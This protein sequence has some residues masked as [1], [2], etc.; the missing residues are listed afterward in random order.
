ML[1]IL[2]G[3]TP[4]DL[5][6]GEEFTEYRKDPRTNKEVQLEAIEFAAYCPSRV[7]AAAVPTGVG[8][9]LIAVSVAK[10]TDLRTV[11]LTATKGLQ[12]Q[13]SDTFHKYGI[14]DIRGKSNYDCGDYAHLDCRQGASVGCRYCQGKGCAYEVARDRARNAQLVVAN[15]A[16]WLNVNDRASGIERTGEN[17]KYDGRNP[18]QL[19]VLDEAHTADQWLADYL[20]IRMYEGEVKRWTEPKDL[21]DSLGEWQGLAEVAVCDLKP[22]VEEAQL[23]LMKRGQRV[24]REEIDQ[25]HK[26][27]KLLEKFDRISSMGEDWVIDKWEGTRWGRMWAMDVTWPG[28]YAEQYLFCNIPKII[29]MSAT[30]RPKTVSLLGVK[31]EDAEFREWA[32]IFPANRHPIYSMPARTEA[33][34]DIRIDRRTSLSDKLEWVEHIDAI[35]DDRLDRKGII[36]TVCVEPKTLLLTT[37]LEWIRADHVVRGQGL[38]GFDESTEHMRGGHRR[39]RS[40]TAEYVKVI[41]RPCVRLYLEDSKNIVCSKDHLWLTHNGTW[42]SWT[43]ADRLMTGAGAS[44]H[45]MKV[46]DVWDYDPDW[47]TGYLAAAF[48]GE[49]CLHQRRR[50]LGGKFC[51]LNLQF[52]QKENCML[53]RVSGLLL[54]IGFEHTIYG[55]YDS[56]STANLRISNKSEVLRFLG[57]VRP[58]RLMDKLDLT[59]LGKMSLKKRVRVIK[60]EFIG[61]QKVISIKTGTSTFIAEGYA[62]HNSYER[63][64]FLIDHSRHSDIMIGNTSDPESETA[65]EIAGLFRK[66]LPPQILVSPSFA[67][68]WDFPDSECEYIIICKVPFKPGHSKVMKAREEKDKAYGSYLAMQEMVQGAGRGMRSNEDRCEVFITDGHLSWFLYQNKRLA[69]GWFVEAVRRVNKVPSA[70]GKL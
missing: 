59:G 55:N 58:Q 9:S 3:Y 6:F 51:G 50:S 27:E 68:G 2:S 16:Y 56:R 25:L 13:Y 34:K 23:V 36:Q 67:M 37:S 35:I 54:D 5:G 43:R 65:I 20:A 18:V 15:Y 21:G 42:P 57:Q 32:R 30:L 39:W 61:V 38:M 4:R 47:T 1:D 62:S 64:K 46:I 70:P 53:K 44:S 63:A 66:S 45:L 52:T 12:Q 28:R 60:R 31:S 14:V 48:E 49:G 24:K 10:L 41:E 8:K 29:M 33:G 19:L 69:P 22:E 26:M 11:I 17:A 7:A 40:T